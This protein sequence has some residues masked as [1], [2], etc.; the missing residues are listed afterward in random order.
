MTYW[1]SL[2]CRNTFRDIPNHRPRYSI[3]HQF[4]QW[5]IQ[6]EWMHSHFQMSISNDN[7]TLIEDLLHAD[8]A[9]QN[10]SNQ[11]WPYTT[12][13]PLPNTFPVSQSALENGILANT[14][15][16]SKF[17]IFQIVSMILSTRQN[18]ISPASIT[19]MKLIWTIVLTFKRCSGSSVRDEKLIGTTMF[20][21]QTTNW[22]L[23]FNDERDDFPFIQLMNFFCRWTRLACFRFDWGWNYH[24][25]G[26]HNRHYCI[27]RQT[28]KVRIF[29][30]IFLQLSLNF[31]LILWT[32]CK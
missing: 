31:V 7:Q 30:D 27:H 29:L 25:Y 10:Y 13:F 20:K 8:D 22:K 9:H 11:S 17:M 1:F 6:L 15:T 2:L 18:W 24:C 12:S 14:I 5:I 4:S 32:L 16:P 21:S 19:R 26:N 23:L 28:Q 3:M